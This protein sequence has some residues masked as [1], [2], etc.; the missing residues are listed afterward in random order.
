[1]LTSCY[2]PIK[3]SLILNF[4][5]HCIFGLS[6]IRLNLLPCA[7]DF[8]I[9]IFHLI[10]LWVPRPILTDLE[11]GLFTVRLCSPNHPS[12][13]ILGLS[14]QN[15]TSYSLV[16]FQLPSAHLS[17]EIYLLHLSNFRVLY[18][19]YHYHFHVGGFI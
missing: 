7:D 17:H 2:C 8:Q 10:P 3:L 11:I 18:P 13:F 16:S 9:Y 12:F 4:N 14:G 5:P 15:T 19:R 1:M 6:H